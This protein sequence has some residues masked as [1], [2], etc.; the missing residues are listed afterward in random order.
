[1]TPFSIVSAKAVVLDRGNVDTDQIIPARFLR[2][3]RSA[4]YENFLFVDLPEVRAAVLGAGVVFAG[5]NFGCGSSR[6]GAVYALIDAGVRCVVAPSFGDIF[7][8]NAGK[9]GLLLLTVPEAATA[10][11]RVA[12]EAGGRSSSICQVSSSLVQGQR[13]AGVRDRPVPQA[14]AAGGAGRYRPHA[15]RQAPAA[16]IGLGGART[17]SGPALG[18]CPRDVRPSPDFFG[19]RVPP[20]LRPAS[21]PRA[22][23]GFR[24]CRVRLGPAWNSGSPWRSAPSSTGC[25]RQGEPAAGDARDPGAARRCMWAMPS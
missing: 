11:M 16:L 23:G 13:G 20:L 6:E 22:G 7:A 5:E 15:W 21:P 2:K 10:E 1:M 3:P 4:G 17:C 8:G 14:H 19:A 9:N 18:D 25:C 24:L 12:V